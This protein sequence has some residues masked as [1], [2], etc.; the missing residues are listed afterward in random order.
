MDVG[1][2]VFKNFEY[3]LIHLFS[4]FLVSSDSL[5]QIGASRLWGCPVYSSL[6]SMA[7]ASQTTILL[8]GTLS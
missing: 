5:L 6:I 7:F 1:E 3:D 8:R 2:V 4:S